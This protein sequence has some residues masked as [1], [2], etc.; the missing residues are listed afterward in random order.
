MSELLN[1]RIV[2][3]RTPALRATRDPFDGPGASELETAAQSF[4]ERA[5]GMTV[6]RDENP[7]SSTINAPQNDPTVLSFA[8][9]MPMKLI[10]ALEADTAPAAAV[11]WGVKAVGADIS[12]FTGSG[13][14]RFGPGAGIDATHPA[15]A[16]VDLVTKS[17]APAAPMTTNGHGTH[18]AETIFGRDLGGPADRLARG[19]QKAVIGKVLGGPEWRQQRHTCLGNAVGSRQWRPRHLHVIGN[20]PPRLGG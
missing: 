14:N 20:G 2:I 12:P 8:P 4:A 18:C 1:Q 6:E 11:T 7:T 5:V 10:E 9:A 19:V 17:R 16:G 3:L 13:V 15:F